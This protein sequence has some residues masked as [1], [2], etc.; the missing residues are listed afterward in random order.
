M[1]ILRERILRLEQKWKA[2]W[3][4]QGI[5]VVLGKILL[6]ADTEIDGDAEVKGD[7]A[8]DG[9]VDGIDIA[10]DVGANTTHRSSDGSDH[11]FIDQDVKVAASPTHVDL[12]LSGGDIYPTADSTT[13][14]QINKADGVTNVLNVDTT[15]SRVGIGISNP[16][17][18]LEVN[19]TIFNIKDVDWN[20]IS[21][22]AS[23][24]KGGG[25]NWRNVIERLELSTYGYDY[26]ILINN[27]LFI[28]TDTNN[29]KVGIGKNNPS[30]A[31]DVSG[32]ISASNITATPTADK[33]PI[34]D[35]N[36]KVDDDWLSNNVLMINK[37]YIHENWIMKPGIADNVW[38][39]HLTGSGALSTHALH[40][41]DLSTGATDTSIAGVYSDHVTMTMTSGTSFYLNL[42]WG[43]LAPGSDTVFV[44]VLADSGT[45]FPVMTE[46]HFGFKIIDGAIWATDCDGTNAENATDTGVVYGGAYVERRLLIRHLGSSIAYYVDNVLKVTHSTNVP[47]SAATQQIY[48]GIRTDEASNKKII[49]KTLNILIP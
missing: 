24:S 47:A 5:R 21:V 12:K 18:P 46:R 13:A 10:T 7:I 31:L 34:A 26:P 42:Q 29:G 19:G 15:N 35:G 22:G 45:R 43:G 39:T 49:L 38:S 20:S 6:G 16:S 11:G 37:S 40:R 3:G 32:D 27:S 48:L 30:V 1:N 44:G 17:Y 14:I 33:I 23:G 25:I 9:T 8:V 4:R 41:Q 28:D 36:G 2:L